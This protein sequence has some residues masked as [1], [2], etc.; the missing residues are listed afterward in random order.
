[1]YRMR[2][3][4]VCAKFAC[5]MMATLL[6]EN[7]AFYKVKRFRSTHREYTHSFA[8]RAA[9]SNSIVYIYVCHYA[10]W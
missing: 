9:T 3:I 2:S 8:I 7:S 4:Q 1:M 6:E 5:A 10:L